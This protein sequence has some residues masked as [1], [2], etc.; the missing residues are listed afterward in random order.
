MFPAHQTDLADA[1]CQEL[2]A[3][4]NTPGKE[5]SEVCGYC[6]FVFIHAS[7]NG[8]PPVRPGI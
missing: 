8:G 2:L 7:H 4:L 5:N 6:I 3:G 1:H